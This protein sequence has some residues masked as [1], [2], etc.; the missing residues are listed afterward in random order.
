MLLR[1]KPVLIGIAGGSASGKTTIA[2][3]IA[4]HFSEA[5]RVIIIK[6]DD[7][8]KEQFNM[9]YEERSK[10]NYDHPLAFDT[11]LLHQHLQMLIDGKEIQKP[12]YDY[13]IHN[14]S[15]E[16]EIVHPADVIILEGLFVLENKDTRS[17]LDIKIFCDSPA[18]VRFIRRLLR[19]VK[20]RGRQL[21]NIVE[22]YLNTVRVMHEEFVEPS[23]RYADLIVPNVGSN[24]VAYDL[25]ITKIN[26]IISQNSL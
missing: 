23:K 17:L 18:D 9:T 22:Q 16:T 5:N 11:E 3:L 19:D 20:E 24:S 1:K 4:D 14:R 2:R 7:Y 6:E 12:I 25:L 15:K 10:I 26:S 8:Y 13:T 21:D